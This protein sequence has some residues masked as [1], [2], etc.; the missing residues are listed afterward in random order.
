MVLV[1]VQV[2]M[3]ESYAV[4]DLLL[5]VRPP[6]ATDMRDGLEASLMFNTDIFTEASIKLVA[7]AH[8]R[9]NAS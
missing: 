9:A 8:A 6:A 3:E 1:V 4:F 5:E 2:D 7:G